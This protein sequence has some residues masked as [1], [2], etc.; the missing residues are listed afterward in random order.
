[1]SETGALD[2]AKARVQELLAAAESRNIIPIRLPGQIQEIMDLLEKAE[3]EQQEAAA[4]AA[5]PAD[6]QDYITEEAYFVGHAVHELRTPMTSIRGYADM[7]GAMGELSDMQKQFLNTIKVNSRRMESLLADV[8]YMNKIRKGT[9]KL[10][11]KMDMFKNIAMKIEK[12]M[13]P[14]A[15]ELN[16]ELVMDIPQGLPLLNVDG[17][18]LSVAI[19]KLVENAL[20]YTLDDGRVVVSAEADGSDLVV[21]VTDNGIGMSE[22]ELARLGEIYYRAD[23]DHVR[24]YKG[25]GLGIP[26][27]YGLIDVLGGTINVQSQPEQGTTFTIRVQGMS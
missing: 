12:D 19:N 18:L 6:M 22:E 14:I 4:A 1:M 16:R 13:T 15:E 23:H 25:S 8:S 9:V 17:D 11:P 21:H 26:I 10:Q 20:R 27:A 2:Q 3:E 7:M 5:V 24:E